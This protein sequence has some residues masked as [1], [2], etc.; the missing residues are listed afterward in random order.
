MAWLA[1]LSRP[2]FCF[3]HVSANSW[4]KLAFCG[5]EE[6]VA[7]SHNMLSTGKCVLC[8]SKTYAKLPFLQCFPNLG[9]LLPGTALVCLRSRKERS[10]A[11]VGMAGRC[12]CSPFH[13]QPELLAFCLD[14]ICVGLHHMISSEHWILLLSKKYRKLLLWKPVLSGM[15]Y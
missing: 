9:P 12:H 7:I 13:I 5:L 15:L 6:V 3:H 11:G 1:F 10:A 4:A 14:Y 2:S 8:W